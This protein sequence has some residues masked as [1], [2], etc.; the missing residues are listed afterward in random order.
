[1]LLVLSRVITGSSVVVTEASSALVVSFS[2]EGGAGGGGYK[3]RGGFVWVGE[4]M[5]RIGMEGIFK[6]ASTLQAITSIEGEDGIWREDAGGSAKRSD[7]EVEE[8]K[9][10]GGTIKIGGAFPEK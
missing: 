10:R 3:G 5:L 8:G 4:V 1:M 2:T 9:K 6:G 7:E